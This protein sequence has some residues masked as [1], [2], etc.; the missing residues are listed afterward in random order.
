MIRKPP[1]KRSFFLPALGACLLA[2]CA[3]AAAGPQ[4]ACLLEGSFT[5][6]GTHTAIKDCL[7]NEGAPEDVFK[8]M[9]ERLTGGGFVP[10]Q[11]APTLTYLPACPP[12][13]QASC[14][15]VFGAPI[16]AYY[17]RRDEAS[18]QRTQKSCEAQ[19]GTWK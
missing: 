17:Y 13:Q 5:V 19:R 4:S 1:R 10:G 7:Q 9:C 12:A 3:S 6:G 8:K 14:Q 16:S 2:W 15:H 11:A 18:L